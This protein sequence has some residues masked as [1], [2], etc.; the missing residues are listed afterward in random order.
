MAAKGVDIL[1]ALINAIDQRA[2]TLRTATVASFTSTKC[3]ITI[4]G[5][6]ITNVPYMASYSPTVGDKVQVL[7][8]TGLLLIL[9]KVA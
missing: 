2:V 8:K 1:Y 5:G 6:S 4:G 7:Q 3:V 9:G